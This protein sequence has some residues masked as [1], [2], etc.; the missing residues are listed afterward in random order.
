[1]FIVVG[2]SGNLNRMHKKNEVFILDGAVHSGKTSRLQKWL[3]HHPTAD[4]ILAPVKDGTRW[5]SRIRSGE[6]RSLEVTGKE[7]ESGLVKVGQH[8]F[9]ES[10][11]VWARQELVESAQL[12]DW[13]VIDEIGPLELT[14]RGLEPTLSS[15]L[16]STEASVVLVVRSNLLDQ[17]IASYGLHRVKFGLPV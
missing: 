12:T 14:G 7:T 11:F 3:E 4:G 8:Q 13:L 9:P 17:V 5:L 16:H 10:V 6:T 1:M 2:F 15:V